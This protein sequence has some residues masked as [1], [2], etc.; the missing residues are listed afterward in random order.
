MSVKIK[1]S[2]EREEEAQA[3]LSLLRPLDGLFKV[4][5]STGR[6]PYKHI[7]FTPKNGTKTDRAKGSA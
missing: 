2:Y 1:I 5:K 6:P 7:F 3:I 4:K